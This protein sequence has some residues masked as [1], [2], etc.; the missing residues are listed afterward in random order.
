MSEQGRQGGEEYERKRKEEVIN[1]RRGLI[2][3]RRTNEVE[4]GQRQWSGVRKTRK[5]RVRV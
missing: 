3:R 4:E 5:R 1:A 2:E